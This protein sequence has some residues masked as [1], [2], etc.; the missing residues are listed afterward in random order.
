MIPPVVGTSGTRRPGAPALLRGSRRPRR[1][2]RH[3]APGMNLPLPG[4]ERFDNYAQVHTLSFPVDQMV[5]FTALAMGGVLDRFPALRLAFLESGVGWVPYFVHRM[6]EHRAK[7]GD[8]VPA[9]TSDPLRLHRAGPASLRLRVRGP[10]ARA[11][12]RAP[13]LRQPGVL[14]G[15]SPLG[16]HSPARSRPT[17]QRR[18]AGRRRARPHPRCQRGSKLDGLDGDGRTHCLGFPGAESCERLAEVGGG[19][20][21]TGHGHRIHGLRRP[22]WDLRG[23]QG[24]GGY[25]DP[26]RFGEIAVSV[27]MIRHYAAMVRDANRRLL[28]RGL[29]RAALGGV[30]AP[31]GMLM[32]W[33]IPL[34]WKPG[35]I[36]RSRCSLPGCRCP[37]TRSSTSPTTP[38]T[39]S[40]SGSATTSTVEELVDVSEA[41]RTSL[42]AGH[43][44]TTVSTHRRQ[45]GG[46]RPNHQR[47]FP[48]L[49]GGRRMIPSFVRPALLGGH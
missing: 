32:T 49:F 29:R 7:R 10:A 34:E 18:P 3:S 31:P 12:R 19:A 16:R 1:R 30:V 41:K 36:G 9:M 35:G 38:S 17:G 8:M 11:L 44:V 14:V 22:R 4:A 23:R 21:G 15:L 37:A 33:L 45:D 40:R 5:A 39:S 43:F 42:G 47:A 27:P 48:L 28:G 24:D 13:R 2:R 46:R 20:S 25:D 6:H 26:V